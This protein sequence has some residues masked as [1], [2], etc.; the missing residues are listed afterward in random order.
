MT[1]P[2]YYEESHSQYGYPAPGKQNVTAEDIMNSH[3]FMTNKEWEE[4]RKCGRF[5][6][7]IIGSSFCALAFTTQALKN[8][9][10]AKILIIERGAYLHPDHYQNLPPAFETTVFTPSETFHWSTTKKTNSGEYIKGLHGAY[11]FF[12]GRS[13][14]WSGWCPEPKEAEMEGW[15]RELIKVIKDYFPKAK[16]MLNVVPADKIFSD[17]AHVHHL[18]IFG[19]LQEEVHRRITGASGEIEAVKDVFPTP[20][21]VKAKQQR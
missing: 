4:N 5:D 15:P 8:N 9:P 10:D 6:Y 14:F 1:S 20:L 3:Y 16:E 19:K 7:V 21:A 2:Q 17:G 11:S 12:G 18:P 13:S